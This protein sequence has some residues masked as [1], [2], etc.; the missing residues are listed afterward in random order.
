MK[1]LQDSIVRDSYD[2]GVVGGGIGGLTA[3]APLA[4][5]G[6]QVLLV[7]Q[8]YMPGG[9]CGAIR[10]RGITFD[11]GATV[12]YGFGEKG[13]N[14]HRYVMNELEEEIENCAQKGY[15]FLTPLAAIIAVRGS[16]RRHCERAARNLGALNFSTPATLLSTG[17]PPEIQDYVNTPTAR[18]EYC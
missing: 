15:R 1:I 7:E 11:V 4:R 18:V 12:L 14:T 10:R 8:H 16:V 17:M 3:A 5:K 6:L 2:V 9:C 13:L